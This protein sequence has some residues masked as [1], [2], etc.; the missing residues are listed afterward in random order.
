MREAFEGFEDAPRAL[1]DGESAQIEFDRIVGHNGHVLARQSALLPREP[2]NGGRPLREEL[3]TIMR[4]FAL[5]CA[6]SLAFVSL[7]AMTA[8]A[9]ADTPPAASGS[10]TYH[11]ETSITTVYGSEYPVYGRLD[12]QIAQGGILRGY[13]HNAYQK[14]YIQVTGGRDGNYVWFDI[15]PTT[16][17]IGIPGVEGLGRVHVIASFSSDGSIHGQIF[18]NYAASAAEQLGPEPNPTAQD[19]YLF[20]AKPVQPGPN[21]TNPAG[22]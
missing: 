7:A 19:Q 2:P 22:P 1:P 6:A 20:V 10:T 11:Y 3:Y 13:Y 12:I 5:R 8:P 9:M 14:A 16:T 15:G 18:P 21:T 4:S 17:D